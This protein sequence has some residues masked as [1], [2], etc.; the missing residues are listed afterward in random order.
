MAPA[1]DREGYWGSPTST[2]EWCE[3]NYAVSYYIAEFC[4]WPLRPRFLPWPRGPRPTAAS[5]SLSAALSA[6]SPRWR[7]PSF[8]LAPLSCGVTV[9]LP[10]ADPGGWKWVFS[11]AFPHKPVSE[12]RAGV[13]PLSPACCLGPHTKRVPS[14]CVRRDGRAG[15][16][17]PGAC[18][19]GRDGVAREVAPGGCQGAGMVVWH[20]RHG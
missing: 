11:I 20:R 17:V 3:E 4:E 12:A 19:G 16:G 5:F 2:L 10:P 8:S 6:L 18:G 7:N 15:A 14:A 13:A 9:P 1:G